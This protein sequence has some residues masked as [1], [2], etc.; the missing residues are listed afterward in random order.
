[1]KGVSE[2]DKK[3]KISWGVSFGSLALVAGMVSYLGLSNDGSTNSQMALNQRQQPGSNTNQ[4]QQQ[5]G[6]NS[7]Q[8]QQL[9]L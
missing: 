9:F 1:L 5:G 3:Q 2:V 7:Q 8:D 4:N 6:L